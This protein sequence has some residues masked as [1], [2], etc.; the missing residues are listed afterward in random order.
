MNKELLIKTYE[1]LINKKD[2]ELLDCIDDFLCGYNKGFYL[3]VN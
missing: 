3:L 2:T 1:E